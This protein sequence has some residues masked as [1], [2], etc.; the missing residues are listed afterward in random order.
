[1]S[2]LKYYDTNTNSWLPVMAGTQG[3]T[4]PIGATGLTGATGSFTGTLTQNLNAN[5]Y[6]ISNIANIGGNLIPNANV[7]YDLGSSTFRWK[8][9]WL[10]NSTIYLGDTVISATG[11]T[12]TLPE[13]SKVGNNLIPT[14][15]S[16]LA[17]IDTN[18]TPEVFTL[19]VDFP[20]SG[21]GTDWFWTW[22]AG[23]VAYSRLKVTNQTQATVPL[24]KSGV[25]T[26]NNFA[27][28]DLHGNMTQTHKIYLKWVNGAGLDNLVPW[29]NSTLNVAGVSHPDI[30]GGANTTIQRL[31]VNVPAGNITMPVLTPPNVTYNVSFTTSGAYTFMGAQAGNN[32]TLGPVY[33]GGTYTFNLDNSLAGHPFYLTTD[34][35]VNFIGNGFVGEYTN[36]VTGSRNTSGQLV[37][38]VPNNAPNTLYYQCGIHHSMRGQINI[39]NL[40]VETNNDG[41]LILYFQHTQEGHFTPV[42][43][44][45]KPTLD[46][47]SSAMLIYDGTSKKFKIKDMG[48]YVAETP[49]FQTKIENITQTIIVQETA[50]TLTEEQITT[51]IKDETIYSSTLHQR[52]NLEIYTGTARWYAPFNLQVSTIS[53][54][55][56]TASNGN[57]SVTINKNGTNAKSFTFAANQTSANVANSIINMNGGDYLT[58]DINTVGNTPGQ[59][60]YVQ[61]TYKKV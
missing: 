12:V 58:I 59:D 11:N 52:G 16:D 38:N 41:N 61:F 10:S 21:H 28:H 49:Q 34:S 54:K 56:A 6:S 19:N 60:M 20:D 48:E 9:L 36:G 25:Y 26:V 7:T 30:N 46:D 24:Y 57:V 43:I 55:L 32:P 15:S 45:N 50:N 47:I 2:V 40:E 17:D 13:G 33:R 23:R 37:F 29:A 22:D 5:N 14:T 31:I 8:D 18:I 27:A 39:K 4:G 44:R 1:M 42:E 3:A 35:G 51:K 53:P